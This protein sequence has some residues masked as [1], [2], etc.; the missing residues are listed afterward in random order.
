M[1]EVEKYLESRGLARVSACKR[2]ARSAQRAACN[3]HTLCTTCGMRYARCTR[4]FCLPLRPGLL[5][6]RAHAAFT[7]RASAARQLRAAPQCTAGLPM[8]WRV[9]LPPNA[10]SRRTDRAGVCSK[11]RSSDRRRVVIGNGPGTHGYA[12][13]TDGILNMWNGL[14]RESA[15]VGARRAFLSMQ[16]PNVLA[17][18][19][20]DTHGVLMG[21]AWGDQGVLTGYS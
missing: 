18:Y 5:P 3:C 20:R 19:S 15:A 13:G 10:R 7:A 4:C 11:R 9:A 16:I 6:F 21:Y 12:R 1:I 14:N 8:R 2:A 17:G